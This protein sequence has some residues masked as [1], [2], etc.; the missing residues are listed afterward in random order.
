MEIPLKRKKEIVNDW[1]NEFPQLSVYSST[2]L[3]GVIDFAII[4]IELIRIIRSD[5]YRPHIICYPLWNKTNKENLLVS[6]ILQEVSNLKGLQCDIP[7]SKHEI[8]LKE[9][10]LYMNDN[11]LIDRIMDEIKKASAFWEAR[12]FNSRYGD[13]DDWFS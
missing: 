7:Y 11:A 8:Y 9:A 1:K 5:D 6:I 4:G 12:Y 3:Y 2:K 13:L 10:A